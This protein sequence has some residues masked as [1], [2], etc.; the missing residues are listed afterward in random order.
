MRKRC[1]F[2]C[3]YIHMRFDERH[4]IDYEVGHQVLIDLTAVGAHITRWRGIGPNPLLSLD[5]DPTPLAMPV[6][7]LGE[8]AVASTGRRKLLPN[9]RTMSD[10]HGVR[11]NRPTVGPL[12]MRRNA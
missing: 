4:L 12:P 1:S 10:P 8:S 11:P 3:H 5:A 2:Y 6:R 7:A 9:D